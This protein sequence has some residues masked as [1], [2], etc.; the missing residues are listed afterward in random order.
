M[1]QSMPNDVP[2]PMNRLMDLDLN[3]DVDVDSAHFNMLQSLSRIQDQPLFLRHHHPRIL[4]KIENEKTSSC[5]PRRE[6]E[7]HSCCQ[8]AEKKSSLVYMRL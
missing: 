1:M 3:V 8:A 2:C 4:E 5:I 6:T 7:T